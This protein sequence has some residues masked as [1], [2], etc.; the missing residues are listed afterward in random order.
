VR[1]KTKGVKAKRHDSRRTNKRNTTAKQSVPENQNT[2]KSMAYRKK[3]YVGDKRKNQSNAYMR[4][5]LMKE[6]SAN[7]APDENIPRTD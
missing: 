3:G 4:C 1:S 2:T 7:V 6:R 5:H